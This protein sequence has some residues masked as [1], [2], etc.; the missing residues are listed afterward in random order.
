MARHG[1]AHGAQTSSYGSPLRNAASASC[2]SCCC[3]PFRPSGGVAGPSTQASTSRACVKCHRRPFGQGPSRPRSR[4]GGPRRDLAAPGS[5]TSESARARCAARTVPWL[6]PSL[7][8]PGHRAAGG[9]ALP[10][11]P[12][13]AQV[14]GRG[15]RAA[16]L[17]RQPLVDLR[18][19]KIQR[20]AQRHFV[21]AA[22]RVRMAPGER[23]PAA[24]T[25]GAAVRF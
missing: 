2:R 18:T 25:S 22:T 10:M 8:G 9:V 19:D 6:R 14:D 21:G 15:V 20:F 3:W 24:R 17:P 1:P 13:R 4:R 23:G 5:A 7:P 16:V 11:L 12:P